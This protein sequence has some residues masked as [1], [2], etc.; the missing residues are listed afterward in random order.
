M[1]FSKYLHHIIELNPERK[2]ARVQPGL[3]LDDLRDAAE[4]HHLTFGP[5]PST[6]NHCTLGGMIGNNSCG[7]H[8]VMAGETSENVL[9]LDV[10]TYD[11]LRLTLGATDDDQYR[12]ILAEGGRRADPH[13]RMR[14]RK[15]RE[16]A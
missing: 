9:S 3:V 11:G 15:R 16:V 4:R 1:D 2:Q 7:V 12:T 14:T 5:D 6:H 8:S 13:K 10:L